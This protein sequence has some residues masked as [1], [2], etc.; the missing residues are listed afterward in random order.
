MNSSGKDESIPLTQLIQNSFE[1]H[2]TGRLEE[3][4]IAYEN[5]LP[6]L[7][8]KLASTL[9]SNVGAIY[10]NKGEYELAKDHFNLAVETEPEN[11]QSHFNLAVILTSKFDAHGK[12]IKHCGIALK[13][14]PGMYKALH[15]M[16]NILQNLGKDV[17]A[18]KYFVMAETMAQQQL[19]EKSPSVESSS[20]DTVPKGDR[21]G[22]A[23]F[24]IMN[25][26][27][28]DEFVHSSQNQDT[29]KLICI[30]ERPLVFKVPGFMKSEECEHIIERAASQ[31]QKSF[32]MGSQ[33]AEAISKP[34]NNG[35]AGSVHDSNLE[36]FDDQSADDSLYRS[37]YNA[38]LHAGDEVSIRLQNRLAEITGFP[39]QLFQ[40]KSEDLQVVKY[41]AGGQFKVHH[42]SSA[43]HP[44]LLT[45]LL[46]LNNVPDGMGG[47]TWFPFAGERKN[48]NLSVEEAI[49]SALNMRSNPIDQPGL[50]VKPVEGDAIIFFNHLLSGDIDPAAVHAGLPIIGESNKKWVANYWVEQDF[51]YLFSEN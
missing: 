16:G 47:E 20:N 50:L 29:L 33:K 23:Q 31:L 42:D 22:W 1:F 13:L 9:H 45:A 6:K 5:V 15:L 30:S 10:M 38:W 8:G 39:V 36:T 19:S 2:K 44:R 46:Y 11:S 24:E 26:S 21:E 27:V 4:I 3:A 37:S 48:F 12:A 43:F 17:D 51:K 41:D 32:V 18:E 49:S 40:Q 7:T 25:A 34:D 28:G 14:D 35:E